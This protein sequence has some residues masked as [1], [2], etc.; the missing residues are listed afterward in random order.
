[1]PHPGSFLGCLHREFPSICVVRPIFDAAVEDTRETSSVVIQT[2]WRA[3][4]PIRRLLN[5]RFPRHGSEKDEA[6]RNVSMSVRRLLLLGGIGILWALIF[7]LVAYYLT[8]KF[9]SY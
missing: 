3:L 6:F 9:K 4:D 8:I 2:M 5:L 1:M 7:S